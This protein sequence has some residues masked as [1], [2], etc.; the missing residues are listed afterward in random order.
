MRLVDWLLDVPT[1]TLD[2]GTILLRPPRASD[3][4]EWRAL[5]AASRA[6]LVPWEPLWVADELTR[7]CFMARL[8]RYRHDARER[9]GYSFFLFD[10]P[11]GALCG[12]ITL[13]LIRR[14]VA[15]TGT[16]GYW[17]GEAF[18]GQGR[19]SQAVQTVASFA[20]D[21]QKLHRLEAACLPR[22]ERSIGLLEKS[23]FSCEGQLRKYLMIAGVWEDHRLYARLADDRVAPAS[24]FGSKK[25]TSVEQKAYPVLHG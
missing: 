13:G 1:P 15:Q 3:F 22:N 25:T 12:G 17:M 9:T 23:G 5:R 7:K 14:G 21:V 8:S 10:V 24:E 19:M 6:F 18:A 4:E 11:T 2:G 16:L 20:F